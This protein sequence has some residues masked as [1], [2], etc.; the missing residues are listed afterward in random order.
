MALAKASM[1]EIAAL[2]EMAMNL[3]ATKDTQNAA[4]D[5]WLPTDLQ[6]MS[7]KIRMLWSC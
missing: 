7:P 5:L 1:D 3:N 4:K 6:L 2:E